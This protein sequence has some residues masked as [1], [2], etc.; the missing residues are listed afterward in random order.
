MKFNKKRRLIKVRNF[1]IDLIQIVV[2]SAILAFSITS[3]MLPNKL[4]TGGFTGIATILYYMLNF[5]VGTSVLL[6]NIPLFL[7]SYLKIG[8]VFFVKGLLG[9][10]FLSIFLDLFEGR[11]ILTQ[12]R[13]L[14]CI[15]GGVIAGVGLSII[16]K[17]N[18]STGGTD[19]LA[20][21]IKKY[22]PYMRTGSL[23]VII[24][25]IIVAVNV[26]VFKQ[27]EIGLYSAIS[28]YLMGKII[29]IFFEGIYFTKMI[30]IISDKY[31]EISDKINIDIGRGTTALYGKGM[32]KDDEKKVLLCVASRNE[33]IEIR[34]ITNKI[35][36][37]AFIISSNAREV[38]GK[39]FKNS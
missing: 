30:F 20:N 31:K 3:F 11:N 23:I 10:I 28:I 12:D 24:D 36:K 35:D 34:K 27:I 29:D 5:P 19:L 9:T 7:I 21:I 32:Y 4:S 8:K 1:F 39:G 2:G 16:L 6:L 38:Y 37:G 15:Y 33:Q 13:L 17:A 26:F 14:A 22:R 18:A 25:V